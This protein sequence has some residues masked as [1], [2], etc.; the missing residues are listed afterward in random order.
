MAMLFG[1]R[2]VLEVLSGKT[3]VQRILVAKNAHG[4]LLDRIF[5]CAGEKGVSVL[6]VPR[7][8]IETLFPGKVHQG[9]V[10]EISTRSEPTY[11]L[12]ECLEKMD[13]LPYPPFLLILDS[14]EDPHNL[15][16]LVRTANA[17]G[18][19][20]IIIPKHR[21]AGITPVVAKTSAGAITST[22]IIRISNLVQACL[23]LK[24]K[25]FWIVGADLAG[26][27]LWFQVDFTCPVV[28]VLGS[29][30]KGMSRL[31]REECDFIVRIPMLGKVNS[32]NVSVAGGI[33]MYEML[34]QRMIKDINY[35][36][37]ESK[38]F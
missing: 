26:K 29:E 37:K 17:V 23:I 10:A 19:Q 27:E 28:L 21:S 31:L 9:V 14:I 36:S 22:P 18:V 13:K 2:P 33:L 32:L 7:H 1:R 15:G 25:G 12:E 8:Q 30:G 4:Y 24:K 3:P 20:G 5:K 6:R 34:R 16:A 35:T 11:S 38:K